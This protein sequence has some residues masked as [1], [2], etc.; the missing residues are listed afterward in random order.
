[1]P[2]LAVA[3]E[4]AASVQQEGQMADSAVASYPRGKKPVGE[5]E[6]PRPK[7]WIYDHCPYCI[8]PR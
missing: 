5:M 6:K 1:M 3:A 4:A 2:S 8:R 7:L